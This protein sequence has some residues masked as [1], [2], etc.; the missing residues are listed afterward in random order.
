[1]SRNSHNGPDMDY[2]ELRRRH[3][4][5]KARSNAQNS[6]D[7]P[8]RRQPVQRAD[9]SYEDIEIDQP[10]QPDIFEEDARSEAAPA[11]QFVSEDQYDPEAE[12]MYDDSDY[13]QQDN[14]REPASDNPF[15]SFLNMA[16]RMKGKMR[17]KR[18]SHREIEDEP[19]EDID[20]D[21]I[22]DDQAAAGSGYDQPR[23]DAQDQPAQVEDIEDIRSD[24][25]SKAA[26]AYDDSYDG[27]YA[28]E[29]Y[30]EYADESYD[31]YADED[32][33]AEEKPHGFKKF[34]SLFITRVDP[35]EIEDTEYPEDGE[36]A[37]YDA[38][39][40]YADDR[41]YAEA[42]AEPEE[43]IDEDSYV[44]SAQNSPSDIEGG[45]LYMEDNR[46]TA[47]EH[48]DQMAEG[49]ENSGMTRRERRELAMR[50]AAEA[51][52][53]READA[54]A[55]TTEIAAAPATPSVFE[56]PTQEVDMAAFK[57]ADAEPV[58]EATAEDIPAEAEANIE[59][60]PP[61]EPT[62]EFKPINRNITEDMPESA[63]YL[64]DVDD[65]FD[66]DDEED[67]EPRPRR[68]LFGKRARK[69]RPEEDEFEEFEETE[70]DD[71]EEYDEDEDEENDRRSRRNRR[72]ESKK[73]RRKNRHGHR[74]DDDEEFEDEFEDEY[75][76]E[77]KDAY[78]DDEFDEDE[79]MDEYD[80]DEYDEDEYDDED[81][82]DE[83]DDDF[84]D[85]DSGRSFGHHLVGV[86]MVVL[87]VI[88]ALLIAAIVLN[89]SCINGGS[90]FVDS[91][92]NRF[93]D[94]GAFKFVFPAYKV[95]T[96]EIA[97]P[98]AVET[99]EETEISPLENVIVEPTA[100]PAP[101][102]S[103]PTFGDAG[104][105]DEPAD[106]IAADPAGEQPAIAPVG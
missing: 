39:D 16:H 12:M 7:A 15:A 48:I 105:A 88:L 95:P 20:F 18:A 78:D 46:N 3:A 8:I 106:P 40:E 32:I 79:F 33:G 76:S 36:Y 47:S 72:K 98:A 81:D 96:E 57:A 52:A 45:Q 60:E 83:F 19:Y 90:G 11:D 67:E 54:A 70:D 61:E 99:V 29:G 5:Y 43:Y 82:E 35:D 92:Y 73:D 28:D 89:F 17:G 24:V 93:G 9:V 14:E 58:I 64:F 44:P 100:T 91:L 50:A 80:D 41:E 62:R 25:R 13:A 22:P 74:D 97:L 77:E 85:D 101:E 56:A 66:S 30:D 68:G 102:I 37:D 75:E 53:V 1:M 69:Q 26:D 71:P 51:A 103:I 86:L 65:D 2:Y 31:E 87:G 59:I 84:D 6:S 38:L 104:T 34:L 49:L 42:E 55:A 10:A 23:Y 94:T 4:A 27:E 63:E 21:D